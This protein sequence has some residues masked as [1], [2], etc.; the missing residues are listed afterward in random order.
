MEKEINDKGGKQTKLGLRLDLIDPMVLYR[1]FPCDSFIDNITNFMVIGEKEY[2]LHAIDV[3][4]PD[5]I[6]ALWDIGKTLYEGAKEYPTNNWRL[7]PQESH[8]NHALVH[9]F[10]YQLGLDDEPHKQHCITRL[11]M[12]YAT[13]PTTRDIYGGY[14]NG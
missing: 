5:R 7:I 10:R 2:L 4:Y 1:L 3:L 12:A 6:K 11:M 14:E 9:Y 8:L 13:E